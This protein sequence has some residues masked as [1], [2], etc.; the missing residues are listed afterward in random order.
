M[1]PSY[2][3]VLLGDSSVGKTSLVHRFISDAFDAHLA[4]TI[5]AAFISKEHSSNGKTVKLEIWDTAGQERYKSLTPMYYRSAKVALVCF[6]LSCPESSF[7]RAHYWV[8]QLAVLGPLDIRIKMVGNKS[9]L[10]LDADLS[11]IES[12]CAEHE[13]PLL[14]TSAK[15]GKGVKDLFDGIV[16][17]T[18]DEIFEE[19]E[20][21]P[22]LT[23]RVR[24]SKCC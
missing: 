10:A 22:I 14:F 12:Y 13:I 23:M 21:P 8:E 7:E 18:S 15:D 4:N 1:A 20:E 6:D 19:T 24:E 2:K 16:A 17:E 5:G 9:D 3:I 11:T